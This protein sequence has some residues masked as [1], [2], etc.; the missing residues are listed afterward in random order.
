MEQLHYIL[1]PIMVIWIFVNLS[2]IMWLRFVASISTFVRSSK[3]FK[4]IFCYINLFG[5]NLGKYFFSQKKF[6]KNTQLSIEVTL[7]S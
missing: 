3:N 7:D 4:F 1:L 6:Q 5:E 2:L